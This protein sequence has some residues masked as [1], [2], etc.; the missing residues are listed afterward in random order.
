LNEVHTASHQ[1]TPQRMAFLSKSASAA[2]APRTGGA[3]LTPSKI[4]DGGSVRFALLSEEPLEFY[5]AWGQ[6]A[7]GSLK[8]FRFPHEPTPEEVVLELGNYEPRTRD[9][10]SLDV[11]FCI[12]L[13]VYH[14][15]DVKVK[16][17]QLSQKSII[18][19]LDQIAQHEDF[20]DLLSWDFTL[21]RTGSKLTTVYTLR[22]VPR[23]AAS[24][25][26]LEAAWT[27]TKA[28][29]FDLARLLV[30]GDPFK[31]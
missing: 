21:G 29:G 6:D 15:E 3:Y 13:P 17:L 26:A 8:P 20:E 16:V 5:E 4:A 22:A 27:D 10:G 14:Y 9:N 24:Q 2:I 11:K 25:K 19:E 23:K 1:N 30:G 28:A 18:S 7:S 31:A 12:A